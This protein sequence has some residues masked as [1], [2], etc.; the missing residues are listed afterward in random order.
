MPGVR[1][2]VPQ[3]VS[4]M[5]RL[6]LLRLLEQE[7]QRP[8]AP[9][10]HVGAGRGVVEQ[11]LP[12]VEYGLDALRRRVGAR[13]RVRR[14]GV[15]VVAQRQ[16]VDVEVRRV[17]GEAARAAV[18][19]RTG[20]QLRLRE[21][22]AQLGGSVRLAPRRQPEAVA[23]QQCLERPL[24]GPADVAQRAGY[25]PFRY[26]AAPRLRPLI[27]APSVWSLRT[28]NS[29]LCGISVRRPSLSG[30]QYSTGSRCA[31]AGRPLRPR[32]PARAGPAPRSARTRR[33]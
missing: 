11:P 23:E 12:P 17:P 33:A 30:P 21:Q 25:R 19:A 2:Q 14:G 1:G 20:E 31:A 26:A 5:G 4:G 3:Q 24:V 10:A 8:P 28:A 7:P 32:T 15:V 27:P 13:V 18:V 16:E 22:V 9:A 29:A 6:F